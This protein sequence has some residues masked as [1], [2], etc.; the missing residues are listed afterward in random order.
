[1]IELIK[2]KNSTFVKMD[3]ETA[4][5]TV[6]SI[7]KQLEAGDPNTGRLESHDVDGDFFTIAVVKL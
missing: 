4:M 5:A 1:M 6:I 3:K 7:L 2:S